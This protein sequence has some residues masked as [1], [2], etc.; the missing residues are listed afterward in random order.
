MAHLALQR[1]TYAAARTLLGSRDS[2]VIGHNTRLHTQSDGSL[3][4]RYHS[5]DVYVMTADG[6]V[7]P[8]TGGWSTV[9][10]WQRINALLPG[11]WRIASRG[12]SGHWLYYSGR[13]ITPYVDGL[14]IRPE[15][16]PDGAAVAYA[17]E[18]ILTDDDISALVAAADIATEERNAKRAARLVREH[19]TIGSPRT[20][21]GYDHRSYDCARCTA[22]LAAERAARRAVLA[23]EHDAMMAGDDAAMGSHRTIEPVATWPIDP[24]T[25][26]TDY[27]AEPT[28]TERIRI[29]CPWD[30]PNR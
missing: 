3:A 9:T 2:R 14:A 1:G 28:R 29:A 12:K 6:W 10:T 20:H 13:P 18:T 7:I 27:K 11:P 22:E 16:G 30:C 4:V 25:G 26:R 8:D 21:R 5:T 19:P 24:T 15:S 17:G 23:A